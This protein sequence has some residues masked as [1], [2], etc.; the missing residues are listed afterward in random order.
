MTTPINRRLAIDASAALSFA[1]QDDP[2]HNQAVNFVDALNS[3]RVKFCAPA[4]FAYEVDSVIRL[5]EW[6]GAFT[7]T[8]AIEARA[9]IEALGVEVEYDPRDHE[10][11]FEIAR[12]YDQPRVYDAA[13]AAHAEARGVE[14]LTTDAPFYEAVNGSKKPKAA[15]ALS[16]VKLLR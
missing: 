14:L 8:Q 4:L 13:Y 16:R 2:N 15:P 3:Q 6:K 12:Q 11:A 1:F 10:R 9:L 5:R 7:R